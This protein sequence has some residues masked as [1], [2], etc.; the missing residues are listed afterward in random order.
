MKKLLTLAVALLTLTACNSTK[1]YTVNGTF[2]IPATFQMGD[3][4]I[5]RGPITG[6]IYMAGLDNQ[7]FDSVLVTN[8]KFTF[9]GPIDPKQPYFVYLVSEYGAG[10]I[11][12]E[13]G[14]IEVTIGEAMTATGTPINDEIDNMM[15][16]VDSVGYMLA[17]EMEKMGQD[18]P[19]TEETFVPV[20]TRYSDMVNQHIDSIYQANDQNLIGVYCANV[21][22]AQAR[23]SAEMEEML[24]PMSD[25]VKNSELIQQHIVYLRQVESQP[26]GEDYIGN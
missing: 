21:K 23:S 16:W 2:D 15:A 17:D 20:Y 9:T 14:E 10:M 12:L 8:E 4:V 22:T 11:A 13:A 26:D 5:E 3:T 19:L 24:A 1:T 18:G 25:Y 7:T 6:Y